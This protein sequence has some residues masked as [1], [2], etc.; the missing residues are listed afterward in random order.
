MQVPCIN[1][2]AA[3]SILR[4]MDLG[5]FVDMPSEERSRIFTRVVGER[6]VVSST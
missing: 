2:L 1:P 5:S 4:Y 3:A 6:R